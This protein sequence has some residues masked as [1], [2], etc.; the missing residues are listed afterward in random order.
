M[1]SP[2]RPTGFVL[3]LSLLLLPAQAPRLAAQQ[4][5]DPTADLLGGLEFRSIGPATMGGRV[6]DLAFFSSRPAVFYV[7][8]ATGGVWTTSNAGTT[9]EPIFDGEASAS[10]GA[11]A[12]AQDDPDLV[13]VGTGEDNNRQSSSWGAG[14]F[15]STD[16]G[17]SWT[18]MGL[19]ETR[20][21]G[22]VVLDPDDH[23]VVYVAA[24]GHLWGPNPERGVFKTTDGGAT[25]TRVLFVDEDTGASDLA[26]DPSNSRVLYAAMY[27]RRRATWGFNGGGPGSGLYKSVDGGES[28]TRLTQGLPEGPLGRI[29][30]DIHRADP[31]I[32]YALIQAVEETGL[33]RSDDAGIHWEK[34]GDTN[35]RP[36][37]FSQVR[38]DPVDADRVYVLGVR[39]MISD[40]GGAT[41]A[42]VR[43]APTRPG[44]GRPRDDLDV[45]ALWID[46]AD[47]SH[48]AIGC[49]VGIAISWDRGVSWD[50][51]N[52][53]PIGQFYHVGYDMDTPYRVYGG[54]QDN[55]VWGGPSASRNLFG[56]GNRDWFSLAIGDGFMATADPG[57]S[58][59]VY[60]E[61][62][63]GRLSL[64]N[65]ETG[66]QR[67]LRLQGEAGDP[68][69]R[70]AWDAP[71]LLSPHDPGTLLLAAQRVYRSNDRGQ[72]WEAISPDLT[73]GA[74]GDTLTIMG[75]PGRDITLSRNDGVSAW[76]TLTALAES[77]LRAGLYYAGSDDGRVHVSTDG[78]EN[79]RDVSSRFPDLPAGAVSEELAPS[80]F[81]EGTAYV[82]FD[83]H[84]ADDYR[85][86]V[87]ATNDYG[88]SWRSLAASLPAGEV[89]NCITE[90]PR[91]PDVLYLGTE[92]GLFVTLDRGRGWVRLKGNLPTVPIDE[93]TIH[94]RDNDLLLA[95]HGRSLWI[96]DDL[97]PIQEAAA[98]AGAQ[99]HLFSVDPAVQLLLKNDFAGYPGDR[100][101]WGRNP[102][103]GAT[104]LYWL[105]EDAEE[106]SL[107]ILDE[108][109]AVVR[110]WSAEELGDARA[111]GLN[112]VPWDL[113]H[114][115]LDAAG[116][117]GQP[118]GRRS[119]R[120]SPGPY[121]LPGDYQV[122]LVVGGQVV[123]TRTVGVSPD[124]L[125]RAQGEDI[126]R[127]HDAAFLL[128][129]LQDAMA[130][131]AI[132]VDTAT[133]QVAAARGL[134]EPLSPPPEELTEVM[135]GLTATLEELARPL[136]TAVR[137]PFG[138]GAPAGPPTL[139]DRVTTLKSALMSWT[140]EP[141]VAQL[142]TVEEEHGEVEVLLH[143][144]NAVLTREL[145]ELYG[146][147]EA[148]GLNPP[149]R[150]PI[151][152]VE[153]HAS[154]AGATR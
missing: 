47:P 144:L 136:T 81:D 107:S 7:G 56:I 129:R 58:R 46:P 10:I 95:T 79:W 135:D 28:W 99:A 14:V 96:L 140:E 97:S 78:G 120:P 125:A 130:R 123:G 17:L 29:A 111:A 27:Q 101:F 6:D 75:V 148:A 145:P 112:K 18:R 49:D 126:H 60:G 84:G 146:R 109:G 51:V 94:P 73:G 4:V 90:D 105:R 45:H 139:R 59:L 34:V 110:A 149:P 3:L 83:N 36:S 102:E 88:Q 40:D 64:V 93:I 117:G 21:I 137:S 57:D 25:W 5:T 37:Y 89:V 68:P 85:P 71:F 143:R 20:H 62:Q 13:W 108:S 82:T 114:Q 23:E 42:E 44:G 1:R 87:F 72:N 131:A 26:M 77:P 116:G 53:L 92:S 119:G 52:N 104:V 128:H 11:L 33:Y 35:P 106:I 142:R 55:D 147:L 69:L 132:A 61:T 122:E 115:P 151:P 153:V 103:A 15:K 124:P 67:S 98:A 121:V 80:A 150:F 66:E 12:V 100:A 2:S 65:R 22:R 133:A 24:D 43:V 70:L 8:A 86:W 141:S 16:G 127:L 118:E 30:V 134:L 19:E 76:P 9:W 38:V 152:P 74:D 138:G 31:D 113:R 41:F 48:L 91:N 32:V 63:N 39:L 50:Y 54:L 154:L